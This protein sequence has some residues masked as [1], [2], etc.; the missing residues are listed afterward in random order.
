MAKNSKD[1]NATMQDMLA[2]FAVDNAAFQGAFRNVAE[3]NE[4]LAGAALQ[5]AGK[6][7][8]LSSKWTTD[9]LSRLADASKAQTDPADYAKTYG[10][11]ASASAEVA[12]ENMAAFA[13]IAKKLQQDTVELLMAAG[14]TAAEGTTSAVKKTT[15]R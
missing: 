12:A 11:L 2:A 15:D 3:L 1:I 6:S 5:A 9:A 14:K 13:E 7:A 10:D 8:E 4:K